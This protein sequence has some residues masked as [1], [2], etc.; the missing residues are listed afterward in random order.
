[1]SN[2]GTD[3]IP[4]SGDQYQVPGPTSD[5][6]GQQARVNQPMASRQLVRDPYSRLGGVASGLAHYF[7]LDVSIVRLGFVLF[8]FFSGVG[9][10]VY[11]L[12]WLV[13]PRADYWPPVRGAQPNRSISAR[14]VGI[15]LAVLGAL[16]FLFFNGGGTA[17]I[18]VPALL[19]AGGVWLLRQPE[20]PAAAPGPAP[21]PTPDLGHPDPAVD[22]LAYAAPDEWTRVVGDA[23]PT[24]TMSTTAASPSTPFSSPEAPQPADTLAD[25]ALAPP[26]AVPGGAETGA[27]G[28][29]PGTPV[30]PRRRRWGRILFAL[31]FVFVLLPILLIALVIGLL[32]GNGIDIDAGFDSQYRPQSVIDIPAII[33]QDAGEVVL[34]LTDLDPSQFVP[35]PVPTPP[36][37]PDPPGGLVGPDAP[38]APQ[39]PTI[40]DELDLPI[41]IEIDLDFGEVRVI[42]PEGLAISVD[43]EADL[44]DVE[45]FGRSEDGIDND[46]T[47]NVDEPLIDLDIRVG[48]G[49]I[50][51]ERG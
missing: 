43:A 25:A 7:G 47:V 22:P 20:N 17:Q 3:Q 6:R 14:E 33:D 26:A 31:F 13:V 9:L 48:A 15:G 4:G 24:A 49:R 28:L 51:V 12:A 27:V 45:V 29:A 5:H 11:L 46:V 35:A 30:P 19:I 2:D 39:V 42:V 32:L 44:G 10:I 16:L 38:E 40:V 37:V 21:G 41:P 50:L 23:D 1:M 8:T 34:D 36:P 18:F